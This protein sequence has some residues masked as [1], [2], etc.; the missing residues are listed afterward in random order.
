[1]ETEAEIK[2]IIHE[3]GITYAYISHNNLY[4]LAVTRTNVNAVSTLYFLH[5]MVDVFKFYF[6]A[7]AAQ[8]GAR[9]L[10]APC[11]LGVLRVRGSCASGPLTA[12]ACGFRSLMR[13]R[14][15]TTS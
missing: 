6:A 4:L 12:A 2:P 8:R 9:A 15:A 1:V 14:C 5:R 10:H 11:P 13:S 7:S 3:E